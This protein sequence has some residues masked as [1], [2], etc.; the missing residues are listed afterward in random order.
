MDK[1]NLLYASPFPPQKSGISDYSEQLVR[2]LKKY[3]N[4]T[5]LIDDY[6]L[7][8]KDLYQEFEV[9]VYGRDDVD[10][11][12]YDYKIYNMG[13]NPYF[14]SYLYDLA[15][16]H[17]GMI[18]LHDFV[19]YYFMVGYYQQRCRVYSK[20]YELAGPEGISLVKEFTRQ[21]SNLLRCRSL[22]PRLPLNQEII[23]SANL[24][25]V[26]SNYTYERVAGERKTTAGIRKIN[27]IA[28]LHSDN[29]KTSFNNKKKLFKKY[30]IPKD[31]LVVSSFGYILPT[32]LNHLICEVVNR[33]GRRSGKAVVYVMAGEG[34]YVDDYLSPSI[35][36]TGYINLAEFNQL[37]YYSDI[38]IN[39]RYPSMGETSAALLRALE[40]GKPCIVSDDA[41]FS[42]L[43][44]DV[45]V[46]I[47]NSNA[48]EELETKL[49]GLL[50][51]SALREDYARNAAAYIIRE[52]HRDKV[53]LEIKS[54]LE[55]QPDR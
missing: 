17:P 21:R 29:G 30:H 5:L 31:A 7:T 40:L 38:M 8:H 37:I 26:H 22:G 9:K 10:F 28:Q 43:P 20:I 3:F 55:S 48:E 24:I 19:L 50:D 39:L 14:H 13:N 27:M 46:K 25:M 4:T 51:S 45:V 23:N 44:D 54:F 1:K 53:A 42:E 16:T 15:L 36:K 12:R 32:K 52:H 6:E 33:I 49:T 34:G 35:I 18:I 11:S 47:R 2:G 41:W